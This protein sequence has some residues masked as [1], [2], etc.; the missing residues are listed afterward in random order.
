ML[1]NSPL[2]ALKHSGSS[3][4]LIAPL[5][6]VTRVLSVPLPFQINCEISRSIA[7]AIDADYATEKKKKRK[8]ERPYDAAR[9]RE[10]R[11]IVV[12]FPPFLLLSFSS[13][14]LYSFQLC[15]VPKVQSLNYKNFF[16][17][18]I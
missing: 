14:P 10:K 5:R 2:S 3:T 16:G 9:A 4:L 17:E 7:G 13:V 18:R 1:G 11:E 12:S 6:L 8:G 15:S